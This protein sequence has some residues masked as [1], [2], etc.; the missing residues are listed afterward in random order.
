MSFALII[1]RIYDTGDWQVLV[2]VSRDLG[3]NYFLLTRQR[4]LDPKAAPVLTT[5][6][7]LT[8]VVANGLLAFPDLVL[9]KNDL[10]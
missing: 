1:S 4:L 2:M 10:S 7:H 3:F 5:Y 6:T 9:N 8:G